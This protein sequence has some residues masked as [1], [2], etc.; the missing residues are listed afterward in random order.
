M[1]YKI[2]EGEQVT[3][4]QGTQHVSEHILE[5]YLHQIQ[6]RFHTFKIRHLPSL[7]SAQNSYWITGILKWQQK[8][9]VD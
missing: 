2:L 9:W 3:L 4:F 6:Q 7:L 1:D 5:K 8:M